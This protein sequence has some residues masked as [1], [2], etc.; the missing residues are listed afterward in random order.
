MAFFLN[1][2]YYTAIQM[3]GRKGHIEV[4]NVYRKYQNTILKSK[5]QQESKC[6]I[7]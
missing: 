7:S 4:V 5:Q 3:A 6:Y 2:F 1:Y